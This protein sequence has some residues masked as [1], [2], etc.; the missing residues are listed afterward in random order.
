MITKFTAR[1]S[2]ADMMALERIRELT[3]E[4][5]ANKA[6]WI[7]VRRYPAL[8]DERN[9]AQMDRLEV[10]RR[11]DHLARTVARAARAQRELEELAGQICGENQG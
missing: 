6:L 5:T 8:V 10:S 4:K 7:A 9:R 11:M 3:G 2:E 1:G